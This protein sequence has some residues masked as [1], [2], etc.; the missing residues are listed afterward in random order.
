MYYYADEKMPSHGNTHFMVFSAFRSQNKGGTKLSS[1]KTLNKKYYHVEYSLLIMSLVFQEYMDL[2]SEW[3][4][5]FK[6]LSPLSSVTFLFCSTVFCVT[7][8][9]IINMPKC[10]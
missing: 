9:N 2:L 5:N 3:F 4:M 8:R 10:V 6:T 1:Y 7:L